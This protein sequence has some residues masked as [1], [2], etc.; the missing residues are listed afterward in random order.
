MET[1]SKLIIGSFIGTFVL[2]GIIFSIALLGP[3][4]SI[5][6]ENSNLLY[7]ND[8]LTVEIKDD[9]DKSL[10]TITLKSHKDINEIRHVGLGEQVLIWYEF[11]FKESYPFG[12]GE[13][14]FID[15]NTKEKIIREYNLV[16]WGEII[17]KQTICAKQGTRLEG[18]LEWKEVNVIT[19]GW[20]PYNS[21]NI[22]KGNI[23]LGVEAEMKMDETIDVIW[24][25]AG[26]KIEK[27]AVVS[28]DAITS[29]YVVGGDNYTV[30]RYL[31]DGTFNTTGALDIEILIVA[32][33][34]GGSGGS[35]GGAGGAGGF[36]YVNHSLT[37]GN[38]NITIGLGGAGGPLNVDGINGGNSLFDTLTA[39]GGGKGSKT[40]QVGGA[41]GSGG[42]GGGDS[43]QA[44]GSG[45]A[46]QGYDGGAGES[47]SPYGGG[48]G[49]GAGATGDAASGQ[50]GDGGVGNTS[51]ITN[52][53]GLYYAG[54]GGGSAYSGTPGDGGLGG[55]GNGGTQSADPTDGVNNTG[56]GGGGAT[57]R[58][59]AGDG[60]TGII[61]IRYLAAPPAYVF[62]N[63]T[64]ILKFSN[65]T[66]V[67]NGDVFAVWQHNN[68]V[69]A[70][71]TTNST[72]GWNF[73]GM[74]NSTYIII[75]Y[76]PTNA[77]IDGDCEAHV[78]LNV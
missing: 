16:Y 15:M 23:T 65:D 77:S 72:G 54:G 24:E 74:I 1:K 14:T 51:T 12:I 29:Y 55:G 5:S 4:T 64:G 48:G 43:A 75:G 58:G 22:P 3:G 21:N 52:G 73:E 27:H 10:G 69:A 61:I 59:A 19:E 28:S 46:G 66:A 38:Y 40:G 17:E 32:G 20:I 53:T 18:C 50:G 62:F 33:G 63:I 78:K 42:G 11:D 67:N 26:N 37:T 7:S 56:A 30:L 60:G 41:G 31:N 25:I 6:A 13:V 2:I 44:G 68:S 34:G 35:H 57:H 47:P 49:G 39:V 45:V 8:N 70:N 71:T 36:M 9:F 76:D